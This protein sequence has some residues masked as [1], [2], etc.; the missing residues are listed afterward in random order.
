MRKMDRTEGMLW[1]WKKLLVET[2]LFIRFAPLETL[3]PAKP[4]HQTLKHAKPPSSAALEQN[5]TSFDVIT[6]TSRISS[7]KQPKPGGL[8]RKLNR[9]P[10]EYYI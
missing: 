4:H 1:M 7:P 9:T 5:T 2:M 10:K 8:C 3:V 6:N